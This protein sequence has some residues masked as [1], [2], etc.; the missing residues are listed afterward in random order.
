[1]GYIQTLF[2]RQTFD[3]YQ[4]ISS[5]LQFQ[6]FFETYC[7]M[8]CGFRR[9]E[10][11]SQLFGET[12]RRVYVE[13]DSLFVHIYL[14]ERLY[15]QTDR[16]IASASEIACIQHSERNVWAKTCRLVTFIELGVFRQYL[17][18]VAEQYR[19]LRILCA[20]ACAL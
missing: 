10:S 9:I 12:G 14:P 6:H 3:M 13:Y 15:D 4:N 18:F 5:A 11:G 1:M 20:I 2:Q 19:M 8:Q 16:R 7:I 17:E